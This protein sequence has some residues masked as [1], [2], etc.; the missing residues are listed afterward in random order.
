MIS[1]WKDSR[2]SWSNC[3]IYGPRHIIFLMFLTFLNLLIFVLLLVLNGVFLVCILCTRVLHLCACVLGFFTSTLI[4]DIH[5]LSKTKTHTHTHTKGCQFLSQKPGYL[6]FCFIFW[7]GL[8]PML[9]GCWL[10]FLIVYCY[11]FVTTRD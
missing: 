9:E 1:R 8:K 7:E 10:S 6:F 5:Y 2:A 3:Y 11:V 4:D